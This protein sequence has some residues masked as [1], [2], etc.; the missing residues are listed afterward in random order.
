[1]GARGLG[2]V[3]AIGQK[4]V[5]TSITAMPVAKRFHHTK[6]PTDFGIPE[7]MA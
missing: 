3:H 6:P 4:G 1:L 7:K 2:I 5:Y